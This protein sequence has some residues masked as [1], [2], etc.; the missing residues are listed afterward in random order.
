MSTSKY[1]FIGTSKS[2]VK[3]FTW[4]KFLLIS[5]LV[6]GVFLYVID[7]STLNLNTLKIHLVLARDED[8]EPWDWDYMRQHDAEKGDVYKSYFVNEMGCR[9]PRFNVTDASVE[10]YVEVAKTA[11]CP[12]ALTIANNRFISIDLNETEI[13]NEYG[14]DDVEELTCSIEAFTRDG[15]FENK[16]TKPKHYFKFGDIVEVNDE[17]IR[18]ICYNRTKSKIYRDYHYFVG[19]NKVLQTQNNGTAES[20]QRTETTERRMNVLLLGLDSISRLNFYRQMNE[21]ANVLLNDMH[22]F[23]MFG[24]NKVGDNTYPNLIPLLTGLDEDEL[25]AGCRPYNNMTFDACRFIWDDYKASGYSTGYFEDVGWMALF[26]Y[27]KEG[28]TKQPTDFYNRPI[29]IELER[30][31]A[32][33]KSGNVHLC[34]GARH[35]F[36]VLFEQFE[37]YMSAMN[38][39]PNHEYFSIFWQTSYSHDSLNIPAIFDEDFARILRQLTKDALK[40]TFL[41]LMSDHG[42]RWGDF[43]NTYQGMM[44][45]RQPF[46]YIV[47][48]PP[49]AEKY[50][51][52]MRNLVKNRRRLT[53]HFDLYETLQDLLHP[54]TLTPSAIK[55]R[56]AELADTEPMPRGISLFLPVPTTRTCYDAAIAPH[57]CTCHERTNLPTTDAR[58]ARVARMIVNTMNQMVKIYP[59]CQ[60]LYLNSISDA[61]ILTS[62]DAIGNMT[63]SFVD[64]TVRLQTKPGFGE[65][66]AT[67]RV[68]DANGLKLTGTISRTNLYGNQSQCIDDRKLKLYCF[69]DSL[70]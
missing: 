23:E 6:L 27:L 55:Q 67:V 9:M 1:I 37:K 34:L 59:K 69:C 8:Y 35:T 31:V 22:A 46:L 41:V 21:S 51:S 5:V 17:F 43:R 49:F 29:V 28:F 4:L 62:T 40:N 58:V 26:Q 45:E 68:D 7:V 54:D 70:Q 52:A 16:Y 38:E 14:I 47:P 57:W 56:T 39:H 61:N 32:T 44:E 66:E 53:T 10:P 19:N 65:F 20:E 25:A 24:Y 63:T 2:N 18:V 50:P 36:K 64:I 3:R 42:I 60:R 30:N 48:P 11:K 15:D 13:M 33:K 12:R